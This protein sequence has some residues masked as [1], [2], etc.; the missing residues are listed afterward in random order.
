MFDLEKDI[1]ETA[2][3]LNANKEVFDKMKKFADQ[4]HT[5]V[6]PGTFSTRKRHERDRWAKWGDSKP[7]APK[8]KNVT[9]WNRKGLLDSSK[10]KLV[11]VSSENKGNG[12]F[13]K[14]AFDG[15]PDRKSVV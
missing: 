2:N 15:D 10:L 1:S 5:P 6:K 14:M 12:K 3:V 11:K 13:A 9:K 7:P 4:S 8:L